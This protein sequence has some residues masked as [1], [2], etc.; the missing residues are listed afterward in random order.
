MARSRPAQVREAVRAIRELYAVGRGLPK[1][2]ATHAEAYEQYVIRDA[3]KEKGINE[4]TLRKARA[5]ADPKAGY[6]PRELR[7]L[8]TLI[9]TVQSGQ[10][11]I[12][13]ETGKKLW[14]FRRT[15][16]IRLLA[17]PKDSRRDIQE[18][19]IKEGWST[20]RLEAEIARRFGT[21]RGGGRNPAA[22]ETLDEWL[23][24]AERLCESW[25][26]WD[27]RLDSGAER[28]LSRDQLPDDLRKLLRRATGP[29][30]ALH[31]AVLAVLG[32]RNDGRRPRAWV[33]DDSAGEGRPGPGRR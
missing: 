11:R 13:K 29:V 10:K 27:G 32:R 5:F 6:T 31:R 8:C 7:E 25:R 1:K 19:A 18:Q 3:A 21:R 17:I 26:R 22:T 23:T 4:D 16:L 2:N 28:Q 12:E 30:L 9:E 33:E 15:H 20:S 24:Q 14:V